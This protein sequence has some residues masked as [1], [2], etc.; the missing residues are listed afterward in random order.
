MNEGPCLYKCPVPNREKKI[1][2]LLSL[3]LTRLEILSRRNQ[4][5]EVRART[6]AWSPDLETLDAKTQLENPMKKND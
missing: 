2:F 1:K 5:A 6:H 3:S 4:K